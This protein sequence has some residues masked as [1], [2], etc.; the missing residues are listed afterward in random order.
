MA[1]LWKELTTQVKPDSI[2][3]TIRAMDL[4]LSTSDEAF[5]LAEM[6]MMEHVAKVRMGPSFL[7]LFVTER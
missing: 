2:T 4:R 5:A 6:H 7:A 1:H 3:Y